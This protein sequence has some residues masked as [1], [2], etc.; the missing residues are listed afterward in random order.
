MEIYSSSYQMFPMSKADVAAFAEPTDPL[1][2]LDTD[3]LTFVA[4]GETK[5]VVLTV[6]N[7]PSYEVVATTSN[8]DQFET[9]VSADKNTVSV[10]AR[11]N[12]TDTA[13]DAVLTV[14][15]KY[16]EGELT[17]TGR[18]EAE[19]LRFRRRRARNILARIYRGFGRRRDCEIVYRYSRR[20]VYVVALDY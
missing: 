4:G 6:K 8:N 9:V 5:Q 16:P 10:I 15:V 13:I 18:L 20:P 17:Q 14:T 19:R 1:L 11:P 2:K 3:N 7:V 12:E